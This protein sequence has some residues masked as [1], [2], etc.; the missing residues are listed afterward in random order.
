[1]SAKPKTVVEYVSPKALKGAPFNP[2]SRVSKSALRKLRKTIE[3]SGRII[4]P[5]II[6]SDN[7]I[8]DGHRRLAVA[9][10]LE[11]K[12][13]PVI[14]EENWTLADLW[15]NLNYGIMPI[16]RKGWFQAVYEGM[17]IEFVPQPERRVLEELKEIAG[18]ELFKE[19]AEKGRSSWIGQTAKM[20][21]NYCGRDGDKE[22][23]RKVILHFEKYNSQRILRN[24]LT[25]QCETKILESAIEEAAP[26]AQFWKL[27]DFR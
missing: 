15:S 2:Q 9:M 5:L 3:K 27:Q 13:V 16:N 8:A 18:E 7:Y 14:R 12:T 23:T 26:I 17:P 24:A 22:F 11:F 10:E 19:L 20:I 25:A 21:A 6:T 4:S 1:M